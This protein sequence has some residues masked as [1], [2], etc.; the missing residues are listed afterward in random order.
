[1]GSQA[2][3]AAPATRRGRRLGI[4]S[5]KSCFGMGPS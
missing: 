4:L 2:G 5:W 1:M 3:L